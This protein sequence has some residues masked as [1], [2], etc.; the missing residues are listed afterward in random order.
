MSNQILFRSYNDVNTY[1]TN[2]LIWRKKEVSDLFIAYQ[3]IAAHQGKNNADSILKS[4]IL[5]IYSNWEGFVKDSLKAYLNFLCTQRL[6]VIDLHSNLQALCLKDAI[7]LCLDEENDNHLM[8]E[9]Q[10]MKKL[11]K[12]SNTQFNLKSIKDNKL[13]IIDT[14][15][16]LSS[17]IYGRLLDIVG[18]KTYPCFKET[19]SRKDYLNDGSDKDYGNFSYLIDYQL[20]N[21]RNSFAHGERFINKIDLQKVQEISQQI[22]SIM[23]DLQELIEDSI[24]YKYYLASNS[25][26]FE[27][28]FILR[29]NNISKLFSNTAMIRPRKKDF[30]FRY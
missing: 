23:D 26:L 7:S 15:S 20:I 13:N 22:D 27:Q 4:L 2:E 30:L 19:Q 25:A 12:H 8:P 16:N 5:I 9:L 29:S 11:I 6:K 17:K 14:Q 24:I 1:L 28:D 3:T 21:I 18:L 10:V